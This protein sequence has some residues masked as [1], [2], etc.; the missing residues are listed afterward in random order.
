MYFRPPLS[1]FIVEMM[2][3]SA[4]TAARVEES[5]RAATAQSW[6]RTLERI[7]MFFYQVARSE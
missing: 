2:S 6:T 7:G 1:K 3:R 4:A 5:I